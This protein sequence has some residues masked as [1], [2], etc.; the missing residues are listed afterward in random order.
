MTGKEEITVSLIKYLYDLINTPKSSNICVYKSNNKEFRYKQF[1]GNYEEFKD[2][3]KSH[4]DK[5]GLKYGIDGSKSINYL[6]NDGT[7]CKINV[8]DY[9]VEINEKLKK[10]SVREFE[11][12]FLHKKE[13]FLNE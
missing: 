3:F 6:N 9:V 2:F 10:Y 7:L 13:E 5:M 1:N 11:E 12:T 8:N 4:A